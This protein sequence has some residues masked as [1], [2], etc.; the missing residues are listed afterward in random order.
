MVYCFDIDGTICTNTEGAYERAEP[1]PAAIAGLNR[2]HDAGHTII[3]F[4][5][6]GSTTG[7]DWRARTEE[8]L[9]AWGVKY[10]RLLFGKPSADV[11]IDDKAVS[12]ETW[13][14][15]GFT[16]QPPVLRSDSAAAEPAVS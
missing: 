13:R 12:F 4:T 7:R 5:A 14:Q 9:A 16:L 3:L 11:Y 8:Q 1:F 2:L 10:H 15:Q 6:R